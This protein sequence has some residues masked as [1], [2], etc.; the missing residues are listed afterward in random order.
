MEYA[1]ILLEKNR[2]SHQNMR[3]CFLEELKRKILSEDESL[4]YAELLYDTNKNTPENHDRLAFLEV[5][6]E[7]KIPS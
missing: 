7:G 3:L 1:H 5:L 2:D 6:R 4:E